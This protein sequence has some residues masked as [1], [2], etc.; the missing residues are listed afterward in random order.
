MG[1]TECVAGTTHSASTLAYEPRTLVHKHYSTRV[2]TNTRTCRIYRTLLTQLAIGSAAEDGF[3][4]YLSLIT[5]KRS[6]IQRMRN[7]EETR[8]HKKQRASTSKE[9][10][11]RPISAEVSVLRTNMDVQRRLCQPATIRRLSGLLPTP[12]NSYW[13][14][15]SFR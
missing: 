11:E 1:R 4:L 12:T 6:V 14:Q 9:K 3:V 10:L 7:T 5:R 2:D 15:A 13:P 8:P